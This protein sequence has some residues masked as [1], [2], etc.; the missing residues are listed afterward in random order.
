MTLEFI[1]LKDEIR[2]RSM[3]CGKHMDVSEIAGHWHDIHCLLITEYP[4][5]PGYKSLYVSTSNSHSLQ[6]V[7]HQG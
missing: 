2:H 6:G 7:F 4:D 1:E 5:S 3:N